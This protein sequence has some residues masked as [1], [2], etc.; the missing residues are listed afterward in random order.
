MIDW[1]DKQIADRQ[2]SAAVEDSILAQHLSL[3]DKE[4]GKQS[5]TP[6]VKDQ[7]EG[8]V[9]ESSDGKEA[10]SEQPIGDGKM[11]GPGGT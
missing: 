3:A 8:K 11:P 2:M 7:G 4:D 9:K 10:E 5:E 1:W 6:A